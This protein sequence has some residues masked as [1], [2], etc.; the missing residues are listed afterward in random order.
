MATKQWTIFLACLCWE[1]YF[2]HPGYL[3]KLL[4]GTRSFGTGLNKFNTDEGGLLRTAAGP[5]VVH[6]QLY[7]VLADC[8]AAGL[9]LARNKSVSKA[10]VM[11]RNCTAGQR[12]RN[13]KSAFLHIHL[14]KQVAP[15]DHPTLMTDELDRQQ[16]KRLKS[17]SSSTKRNQLVS[18]YGLKNEHHAFTLLNGFHVRSNPNGELVTVRCP[19][20]PEDGMHDFLEGTGKKEMSNFTHF[21]VK[22]QKVPLDVFNS[23]I[24][25]HTY[26]KHEKRDKPSRIQDA[27]VMS[28]AADCKMKQTAGQMMVLLRNVVYIF[29][30]LIVEK[31]LQDAP[32]WRSLCA[33]V[34][35]FWALMGLDLTVDDLL[36]IES[37]IWVHIDLY[38]E[39]YG[40]D[41]FLPKHHYCTHFPFSIYMYG[42]MRLLMCMKFEAKHQWFKKLCNRTSFKNILYTLDAAHQLM[43]AWRHDTEFLGHMSLLPVMIGK[44]MMIETIALGTDMHAKLVKLKVATRATEAQATWVAKMMFQGFEYSITPS[45]DMLV[46]NKQGK[47]MYCSVKKILVVPYEGEGK[48]VIGAQPYQVEHA[49]GGAVRIS[50]AGTQRVVYFCLNN[51]ENLSSVK[52]T[53]ID[54]TGQLYIIRLH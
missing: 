19:P 3:E 36:M 25:N 29:L 31:G 18:Q 13:C 42:P 39:A 1:D 35:C 54:H 48:W 6:A 51:L 27:H 14:K 44:P 34:V 32:Q 28:K 47:Q 52:V 10:I 40:E 53:P 4:F 16:R 5:K 49:H 38:Q 41:A 45:T 33:F 9:L 26:L 15:P 7:V 43:I 17:E 50:N 11:C 30:P 20:A 2:K 46:V 12:H 23:K 24:E 21:M 8:P 37:L 22:E